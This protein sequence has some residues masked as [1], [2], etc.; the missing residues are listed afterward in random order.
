MRN[1]PPSPQYVPSVDQDY[2]I[3]YWPR[4]APDPVVLAASVA[5]CRSPRSRSSGRGEVAS[6]RSPSCPQSYW[7]ACSKLTRSCSL[8]RPPLLHVL[9]LLLAQRQQRLLEYCPN[10]RASHARPKQNRTTTRATEHASRLTRSTGR[11]STSTRPMCTSASR[12]RPCAGGLCA[13]ESER[14]GMGLGV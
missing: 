1:Q 14:R 6:T 10:T 11:S 7:L 9:R 5:R 12:A 2:W 4:V 8:A 13:C 3:T